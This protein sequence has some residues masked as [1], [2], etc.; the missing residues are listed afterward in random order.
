MV[1][2]KQPPKKKPGPMDDEPT[3]LPGT[4]TEFIAEAKA[5]LDAAHGP[6]P[7]PSDQIAAAQRVA[8]KV[9]KL[10]T[11]PRAPVADQLCVAHLALLAIAAG[12]KSV[13]RDIAVTALKVVSS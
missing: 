8:S 5:V 13:S 2:K 7:F 1:F 4:P 11:K 9:A 6:A 3:P 12:P 10:L